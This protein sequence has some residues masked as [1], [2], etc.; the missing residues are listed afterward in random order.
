MC[1]IGAT[2]QIRTA[3]RNTLRYGESYYHA[4]H[5]VLFSSLL[6]KDT[7]INIYSSLTYFQCMGVKSDITF[8]WEKLLLRNMMFGKRV[9]R[10]IFGLE[11]DR[12][13][14]NAA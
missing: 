7:K 3:F 10:G 5:N 13:L 6:S 4:V 9:E 1:S 11:S 8:N 12:R 14:E 2:V